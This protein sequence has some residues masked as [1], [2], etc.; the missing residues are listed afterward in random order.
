[1]SEGGCQLEKYLQT[2]SELLPSALFRFI[3]TIYNFTKCTFC[4]FIQKGSELFSF[5][6][7]VTYLCYFVVNLKFDK[8]LPFLFNLFAKKNPGVNFYVFSMSAKEIEVSDVQGLHQCE[9]NTRNSQG[10]DSYLQVE[11]KWLLF[12]ASLIYFA[13]LP[14]SAESPISKMNASIA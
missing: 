8:S 6:V 11:T 1:M 13:K 14:D 2:F 10:G 4:D 3:S 5:L 9:E 7:L 12:L